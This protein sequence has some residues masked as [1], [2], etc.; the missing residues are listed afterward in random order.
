MKT[1]K[2]YGYYLQYILGGITQH[3]SIILH[4][5]AVIVLV[6]DSIYGNTI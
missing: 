4:V 5:Q 6:F 3:F 2:P 1:G